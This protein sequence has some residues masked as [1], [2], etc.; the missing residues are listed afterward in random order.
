M[1]S[2]RSFL[3]GAGSTGL[4][5][6]AGTLVGDAQASPADGHLGDGHIT[7]ATAITQVYGD[8]QKLLAVALRYDR[9]IDSRALRAAQF[10][11]ADRT[12]EKVYAN[13]S[14]DLAAHHHHGRN[15]RFVIIEMSP[16]D[17]AA[18]LWVLQMPTGGP[19]AGGPSSGPP[20][21]GPPPTIKPAV[22]TVTQVGA[23]RSARG[24]LLAPSATAITTTAARN[25]LVDAFEQ[26]TFH[27]PDT[28]DTLPYNLFF[29]HNYDARKRYP[30]VLFMH[31]ASVVGAPVL[32]PLVQ[33]L[34]AVCWTDPEDQAKHPC[35]VL[36]PQYPVV[37]VEDDYLPNSYFDTTVHLVHRL[38]KK[39]SID[40]DRR[41]TTGQSMGAM[42]SL[43][44]DIKY[45]DLFAASFI[46]AGQWPA[47]Q[48]DP[49][50]HEKM[51]V[52]VSQGDEKA[53][54]FGQAM[55]AH[56]QALGADIHVDDPMCRGDATPDE[57][58]AAARSV[59]AHHAPI[60]FTTFEAGT[61]PGVQAGNS[62]SEHTHT[63]WEAYRSTVIRDWV[64]R[65]R[66]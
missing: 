15:G 46:V 58:N 55:V 2:R 49:L 16:D 32:G 43:G 39:Y 8:G 45:P 64:M 25:L 24:D 20:T 4:A 3:T 56:L 9:V 30:L 44:M 31:D 1:I 27:D 11:V 10:Q 17:P 37:V 62:G 47:E 51:W 29:P 21:G 41:Y 42:L 36:A 23:V 35:F 14:P 38:T 40:P 7:R 52:L 54:P 22:A 6:A 53:H 59:E 48:T 63:W 18:A 57:L 13:T 28:G 26:F 60:Y 33:G 66:R 19:G 50:A 61:L 5:I 12:V 34:G 65:Q